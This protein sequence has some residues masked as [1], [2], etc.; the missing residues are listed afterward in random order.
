MS[1]KVPCEECILLAICIG[2][3]WKTIVTRSE[4]C[5]ILFK[6]IYGANTAGKFK[7]R[8]QRTRKLFKMKE[9][10]SHRI[11]SE[12]WKSYQRGR[13]KNERRNHVCIPK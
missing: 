7:T 10:S 9:M 2:K 8:I 13:L 5:S 6:Y 3:K 12:A 1:I 4:K 11:S